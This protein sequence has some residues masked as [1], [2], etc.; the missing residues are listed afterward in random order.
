MHE[1]THAL[2]SITRQVGRVEPRRVRL[3]EAGGL[4]LARRVVLDRDSPP[5]DR[6]LLDGYAIRGADARTGATLRVLGRLEAGSQAALAVAAS[7][8]ACVAINTGAAMPGGADTVVKVED[9]RQVPRKDGEA[10]PGAWVEILQGTTAGAG[11]AKHGQDARQGD[12]VLSAGMALGPAQLAVAAAAGAA[13]VWV[14]PR[15]RVAVL[16]TGD[17]LVGLDVT[18]GPAQIRDTNGVLLEELVRRA[19]GDLARVAGD[20]GRGMGSH[21]G[22]DAGPLRVAME[23]GLSVADVLVVTG[24][25]SMGTKDLVPRV[26]VEMGVRL[27]VERVRMKPGKPFLFGTR[28]DASGRRYVVGLPGNPVSA[29]VCFVRLVRPLLGRL[30]GAAEEAVLVRAASTRALAGNGDREFYQPGVWG[31]TAGGAVVRPL[32]WKGSADI[33]TLAR[34]NALIVHPARAPARGAGTVVDIL[35]L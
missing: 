22:D 6:A 3:R 12:E 10:D 1:V 2:D 20:D 19:G 13:E 14:L 28:D 15:L 30:R 35:R 29:F 21:V 25:M 11:V 16:T 5:F 33:F 32:E 27:H 9:T 17:E 31:D 34:A 18:P 4:V 7:G 8:G 26:L 24:G 23:A